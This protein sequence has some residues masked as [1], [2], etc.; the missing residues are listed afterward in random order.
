VARP[1]EKVT[2]LFKQALSIIAAKKPLP[3]SVAEGLA[4]PVLK[5]LLELDRELAA[6]GLGS[7]S[8]DAR[9]KALMARIGDLA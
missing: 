1:D 6:R 9:L 3:A 7:A 8:P 4:P 2:L 5:K